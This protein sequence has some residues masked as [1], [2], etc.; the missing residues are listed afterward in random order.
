M[1]V[2]LS[3]RDQCLMALMLL[4]VEIVV[5]NVCKSCSGRVYGCALLG[6]VDSGVMMIM[7]VMMICMLNSLPMHS[8]E[9]IRTYTLGCINN[10]HI[11][12]RLRVSCTS[13]KSSQGSPDRYPPSTTHGVPTHA[14]R[15][16]RYAHTDKIELHQRKAE[17]S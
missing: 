11:R 10:H 16:L 13:I 17:H 15:I 12:N 14:C 8:S 9:Q 7:I 4:N 5:A 1:W 2:C 6:F 3:V